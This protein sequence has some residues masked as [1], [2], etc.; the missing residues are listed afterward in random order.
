VTWDASESNI[1]VD[2]RCFRGEYWLGVGVANGMFRV[3]CL[4]ALGD[5]VGC[6]REAQG[7]GLGDNMGCFRRD[8]TG[9]CRR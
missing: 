5:D 9:W 2:V 7:D 6:F 1:R 3:Y 4:E 8:A